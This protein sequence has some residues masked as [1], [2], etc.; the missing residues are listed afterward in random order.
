VSAG[1]FPATPWLDHEEQA[2][3]RRL[4]NVQ[5]RL[6]ARLDA[7]LQGGHGLSLGDYE[8]LVHLSEAPGRS[9]RMSE[10]AGLLSLSPSGVTRRLD[11]LVTE[12]LVVRRACPSDRRGSLAELT[13]RGAARLAAAAVTHVAGV[14]RYLF[15]PLAPDGIAALSRGLRAI[16]A[17]LDG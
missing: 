17:S 15:D 14:R 1:A 7:E 10:L 4:L 3:W 16:T 13:E 12:A 5:G 8:V 9:M 2:V 6:L 11:G